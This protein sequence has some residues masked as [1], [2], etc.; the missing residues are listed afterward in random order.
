MRSTTTEGTDRLGHLCYARRS[1][2][3]SRTTTLPRSGHRDW[4]YW[5]MLE[6]KATRH[7]GDFQSNRQ[8]GKR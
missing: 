8:Q 3:I 1:I 6:D 7:Q 2:N 4:G 5:N